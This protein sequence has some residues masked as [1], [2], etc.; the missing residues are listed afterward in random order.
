MK[1]AFKLAD[2]Q[3]SLGVLRFFLEFGCL[4]LARMAVDKDRLHDRI[5]REALG[6]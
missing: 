5:K 6:I 2:P 4:K 3:L 1:R